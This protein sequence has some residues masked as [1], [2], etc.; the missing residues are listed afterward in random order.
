MKG[1]SWQWWSDICHKRCWVA[2]GF[3]ECTCQVRVTPQ[4]TL[5]IPIGLACN[6]HYAWMQ[7]SVQQKRPEFALSLLRV[8]FTTTPMP[9][10]ALL[11]A[12]TED[13]VLW[14]S[15]HQQSSTRQ[16]ASGSH[17]GPPAQQQGEQAVSLDTGRSGL[18]RQGS[19]TEVA[20]ATPAPT[21]TV[22]NKI[23]SAKG[24]GIS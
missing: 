10:S 12:L 2:A 13:I 7:E 1:S 19:Y 8:I 6:N 9:E 15:L 17:A 16:Q 11:S 22:S 14:L 3:T 24:T 4:E 18:D 23:F 5:I 20:L 21:D